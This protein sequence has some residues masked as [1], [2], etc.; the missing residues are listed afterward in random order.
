MKLGCSLENTNVRDNY[1]INE[2]KYIILLFL[3]LL[4]LLLLLLVLNPF[5]L[6]ILGLRYVFTI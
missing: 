3:L 5:L 1:G 2:N 4:L 6:V